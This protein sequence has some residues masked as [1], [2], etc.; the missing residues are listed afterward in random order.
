ML[1]LPQHQIQP[2]QHNAQ[3]RPHI[4]ETSPSTSE[5]E[6]VARGTWRA[7]ARLAYEDHGQSRPALARGRATVPSKPLPTISVRPPSVAPDSV[8]PGSVTAPSIAQPEEVA[9]DEANYNIFMAL[10]DKLKQLR[11][12]LQ[13]ETP[14]A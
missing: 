2:P 11:T 4:P 5:E 8:T 7:T 1:H 6:A 12:E 10:Q 14:A 9:A 13:I 3:S